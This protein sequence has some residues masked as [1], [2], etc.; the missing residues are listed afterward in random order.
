MPMNAVKSG[1]ANGLIRQR[2]MKVPVSA[3]VPPGPS[4]SVPL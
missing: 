2:T 1:C 3:S 4:P